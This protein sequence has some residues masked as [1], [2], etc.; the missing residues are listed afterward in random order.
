MI[1]QDLKEAFYESVVIGITDDDNV[2][3]KLQLAATAFI[4]GTWWKIRE[5]SLI[6]RRMVCLYSAS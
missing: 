5:T 4:Y 1:F 3:R 6:R 2:H